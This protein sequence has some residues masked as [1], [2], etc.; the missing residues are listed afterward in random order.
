MNDR[1]RNERNR[2]ESDLRERGRGSEAGSRRQEGWERSRAEGYRTESREPRYSSDEDETY[3]SEWERDG[4]GSFAR[5][6]FREEDGGYGRGTA[7]LYGSG[8]REAGGYGGTAGDYGRGSFGMGGPGRF[9]G[10][11]SRGSGNQGS[12]SQSFGN[13]SYGSRGYGSQGYG[14]QGSGGG[15]GYGSQGYGSQ[16][17][18]GGQ[19]YGSQGYGS[20]GYGSQG[21]GS[22]G[23]TS[24][25]GY[26][27]G[28]AGFSGGGRQQDFGRERGIGGA[29]DQGSRSREFANP[30]T[31][32]RGGFAGRGPKGYTRTDDRIREDVCERLSA[33][34]DVDASEIE[35]KVNGGE[36]TLEGNVLTRSMKHQAEDIAENVSGVRD[37]HNQLKVMKGMLSELKD[38]LS[39]DEREQHFA[40]GGTKTT[41]A[42]GSTHVPRAGTS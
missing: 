2:G 38:K 8:G 7:G 13:Q 14:S 41:P 33:D 29:F 16:G 21:Y 22:Q 1:F 36:V 12:G 17:S 24:S 42:S 34:D 37:V 10:Q 23:R 18:G 20:Q 19:G 40:N 3:G 4:S 6:S 30:G 26:Y 32:L 11:G 28:G 39:G 27:G 35:V 25:S 9:S 5:D 15:Q 31:D